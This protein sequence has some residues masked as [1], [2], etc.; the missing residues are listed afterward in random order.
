M[1]DKPKTFKD[2]LDLVEGIQG[3]AIALAME[4]GGINDTLKDRIQI[5]QDIKSNQEDYNELTRMQNNLETKI[6]HYLKIGHTEIAKQYSVELE[7]LKLGRKRLETEEKLAGIKSF[8]HDIGLGGLSDMHD[9]M[10]EFN[11]LSEKTPSGAFLQKLMI[12]ALLIGGMV[13]LFNQIA[14]LT[15]QI[16]ESFGAP[17]VNKFNTE[18]SSARVEAMSLGFGMEE[19]TSSVKELTENFGMSVP[20]AAKV[21][22]LSMDTAR[23]LGMGVDETAKLTG[24]LMTMGGHSAES[25]QDFMKS[26]AALAMSADVAPGAVMEDIASSSEAIAGYTVGTGENIVRAAVAARQLGISLDTASKIADGLLDFQS[27]IKSEMEAEAMLGRSLNLQRARELAL[28]GDLAGM[29]NEIASIVG[30]EAE[31]N[32]MNVLQRKALANALG[33]EVSELGKMVSHAGKSRK[34]LMGMADVDISEIVSE[35]ALSD[36]TRLVNELKAFGVQ[37]LSA[38]AGISNLFGAFGDL[39][40]GIKV[41]IIAILALIGYAVVYGAKSLITMAINSKLTAS[42]SALAKSKDEASKAGKNVVTKGVGEQLKSIAKGLR[43]MGKGTFKG[44]LALGLFGIAALAAVP[45]IPFM[46]A[47]SLMGIPFEIGL[48][49]IGRGV[50]ALGMMKGIWMGLVALALL[51][52]ALIPATFAFS[53]LAGVDYASIIAFSASIII[54]GLAVLGLGLIMFSGIGALIFGAGLLALLGLGAA[55]MI[56]GFGMSMAAPHIETFNN[57]LTGLGPTIQ[58]LIPQIPMMQQLGDG[59]MSLVGPLMFLSFVA[60]F[61][62]APLTFL[63]DVG[64]RLNEGFTGFVTAMQGVPTLLQQLGQVDTTGINN[65][66]FALYNLSGALALVAFAGAMA[67]PVL[68]LLT[69]LLVKLSE[70]SGDGGTDEADKKLERIDENMAKLVAGFEDGTYA[71][72]IGKSA[73]KHSPTKV[74]TKLENSF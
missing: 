17:G 29:Q 6:A 5:L 35:D 18:L 67:F 10:V 44:I 50:S 56:L 1:P 39:N 24:L 15:D 63:A 16:G 20:D 21:S 9:K 47:A 11:K 48:R 42:F 38:V 12:A 37:V 64:T 19:V 27:S 54:L 69:P 71:E 65:L 34:E 40:I 70:V 31:F 60:A 33:L 41:A 3:E 23:A 74:K 4:Q 45:A 32:A 61:A 7:L 51:G 25:A 66:A 8:L 13:S 36:V 43:A 72:L 53:L 73:G 52:V 26:A 2:Q 28:A 14:E 62:M 57:F 58:S 59:I 49:A 22:E 46:I 55:V 30:S 68:T